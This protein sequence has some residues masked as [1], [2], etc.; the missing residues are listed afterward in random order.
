VLEEWEP[1]GRTPEEIA[2]EGQAVEKHRDLVGQVLR[3][4]EMEEMRPR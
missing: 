1:R 2:E 3:V 4:N